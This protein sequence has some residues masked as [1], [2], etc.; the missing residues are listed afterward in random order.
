MD[1]KNI[2]WNF[3]LVSYYFFIILDVESPLIIEQF[4]CPDPHNLCY[5]NIFSIF[6]ASKVFSSDHITM[7]ISLRLL[8][9]EMFK[10][11][12]KIMKNKDVTLCNK[13][14]AL[15]WELDSRQP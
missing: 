13:G 8:T 15:M 5:G 7:R 11:R 3:V 14:F 10:F 2:L 4:Y 6:L 12:S 1:V 9:G